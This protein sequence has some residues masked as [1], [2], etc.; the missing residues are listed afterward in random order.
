[1]TTE[2]R[3]PQ[4]AGSLLIHLL[5]SAH[6]SLR[7]GHLAGWL[8]TPSL[9]S[10]R[11]RENP[12]WNTTGSHFTLLQ[13]SIISIRNEIGQFQQHLTES[14][15]DICILL[16]TWLKDSDEEKTLVSQIPSP[17]FNIISYPG[18]NGRSVGMAIIHRELVEILAH[19][20]KYEATTMECRSYKIKLSCETLSLYVIYHILSTSVLQLCGKLTTLLE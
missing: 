16:E 14:S 8:H 5:W 11:S 9:T 4:S 19:E 15:T 20:G 18:K 2:T 13:V 17:G 10:A 12:E 6:K 7:W 1:M 3:W